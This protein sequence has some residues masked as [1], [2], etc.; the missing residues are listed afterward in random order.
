MT[1]CGT[2]YSYKLP[3]QA[4]QLTTVYAFQGGGDGWYPLAGIMND[5]NGYGLYGT[6]STEGPVRPERFG[7]SPVHPVSDA[8]EKT[9]SSRAPARSTCRRLRLFARGRG[10]RP[11]VPPSAGQVS[12]PAGVKVLPGLSRFLSTPSSRG[13]QPSETRNFI[14]LRDRDRRAVGRGG[15]RESAEP[16]GYLDGPADRSERA[17]PRDDHAQ[18]SPAIGSSA[19]TPRTGTDLPASS[20]ATPRS[21]ASG[22][23]RAAPAG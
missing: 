3:P 23:V 7:R 17:R 5:P 15:G 14:D 8:R 19:R 18:R 12:S 6:T 20:S 11:A 4:P 9:K 13:D 10:G 1:G 21:T 2:I 16:Y 22:T